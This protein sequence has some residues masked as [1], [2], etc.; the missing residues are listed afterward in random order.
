MTTDNEIE[1]PGE[2]KFWAKTL[3]TILASDSSVQ[4]R[5]RDNHGRYRICQPN[6]QKRKVKNVRIES[7]KRK[8]KAP[9]KLQREAVYQL[10]HEIEKKVAAVLK[11][12]Q[13]GPV[14]PR[15]QRSWSSTRRP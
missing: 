11:D 9:I 3:S 1:G 10:E 6:G 4:T 13:A 14:L 12:E 8:S 5:R 7:D 2:A 15:M